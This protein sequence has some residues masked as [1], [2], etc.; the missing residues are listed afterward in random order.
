MDFVDRHRRRLEPL[1]RRVAHAYW[2]VSRGMTLG[3]RGVVIDAAG[4]V[5]LIKHSYVSGWHLPGGGVEPGETM[6]EALTREL[7][8]EGNVI[9]TA[10]PRLHG[11]FF[12]DR[13][14]R[15]DHVAVYIIRE[16]RQ[17]TAPVP[18]REIISHG[19]YPPDALPEETTA[20][21]RARIAEVLHGA[22]IPER[23]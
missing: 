22:P 8:E 3:V 6:V 5:F 20:G 19:F 4:H 23:W 15:R 1:I 18:G 16:F 14:S 2:R 10:T 13:A 17:D 21:P 9:V 11:M 12:N 7:F